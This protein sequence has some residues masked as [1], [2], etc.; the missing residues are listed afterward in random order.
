MEAVNPRLMS[1]IQPT[2]VPHVGNYLGAIQHWKQLHDTNKYDDVV[3]VIVDLHSITL[4]Q[5]PEQLR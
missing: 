5:N 3:I 1:G 4:P 2:G